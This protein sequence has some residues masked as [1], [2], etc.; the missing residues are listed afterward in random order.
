VIKKSAASIAL[1][2]LLAIVCSCSS[3]GDPAVSGAGASS[4]AQAGSPAETDMPA[5][6]SANNLDF[7]LTNF[8][9]TSLRAVY[10]SP[11]D[12]SGWEENILAGS[13]LADGDTVNIRFSPVERAV[14]WDL[15]V[16]GVDEHYAEWKSINLRDVSRITLRFN[17]TGETVVAAEIE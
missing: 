17:L 5:D 10:I 14:L 9:G 2:C 15:K 7:A 3:H 8:T 1:A 13:E 12:A 6:G 16:E 4:R 11:S